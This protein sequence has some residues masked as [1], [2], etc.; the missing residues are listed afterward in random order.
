[1]KLKDIVKLG[2][3]YCYCPH[4]GNDKIGNNE[5]KLIVEEHTYYRECSCGF[6]ILIDD[7]KD[8]I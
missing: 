3:K 2:E 6:S 4:C 1:M 7:R 5:G 8:E